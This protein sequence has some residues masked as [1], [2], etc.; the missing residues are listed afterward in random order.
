MGNDYMN[1]RE[2]VALN[3]ISDIKANTA[4][5][6]S[7]TQDAAYAISDLANSVDGLSHGIHKLGSA[8]VEASLINRQTELDVV[9]KKLEAGLE[10]ASTNSEIAERE[11]QDALG[12]KSS[13][14]GYLNQL[15]DTVG[16]RGGQIKTSNGA[17]LSIGPKID[18]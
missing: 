12:T 9:T 6:A 11:I 15:I 3:D 1:Y 17:T 18:K 16:E 7:A 5:I 13:K 8:I 2:I 10:I 4:E 14:G